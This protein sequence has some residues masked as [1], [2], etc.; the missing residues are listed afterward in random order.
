MTVADEAL[1]NALHCEMVKYAYRQ[2]KDGV[3]VSFVVH[4]NDVPAELSAAHIGSRY[5]VAL[6]ELGDDE[7]P[8][9]T[10]KDWR[11]MTPASQAAIR[12]GD[13]NFRDFLRSEHGLNTKDKDEAA[14][15]I[16]GMCGVKSRMDLATNHK[17]RTLWHQIDTQYREWAHL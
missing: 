17:A 10:K 3:V 11:E 2:T 14:E 8:K 6:V 4:P 12:C 15:A 7:R 9:P 16:R 5:M 1:N 13:K